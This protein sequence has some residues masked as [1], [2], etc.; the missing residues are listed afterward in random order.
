[1]T[2]PDWAASK[3]REE[4]CIP[5]EEVRRLL[6]LLERQASEA[7]MGSEFDAQCVKYRLRG[8]PVSLTSG[9]RVG[10]IA[11]V[12]AFARKLTRSLAALGHHV[13]E[14]RVIEL[15]E[16]LFDDGSPYDPSEL[17]FF[18]R[19][20][21][22]RIPLTGVVVQGERER[23][24]VTI[25]W[26]FRNPERCKDCALTGIAPPGSLP[27]RLGLKNV[28]SG[29]R[30]IAFDVDANIASQ[31]R[32]PTVFDSSW[33]WLHEFRPGGKTLPTGNY[34]ESDGLDE[35]VSLPP[36]LGMLDRLPLGVVTDLPLH[37]D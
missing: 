35:F 21:S 18:L 7:D 20:F 32:V 2:I 8:S 5:G 24:L 11:D 26:M 17:E 19:E 30:F 23:A 3:L 6:E 34:P 28:Q 15:L 9:E 1:M 36:T 25:I 22:G 16:Q 33:D 13:D 37:K 10:R 31:P 14:V 4:R 12:P 27:Y 29:Q